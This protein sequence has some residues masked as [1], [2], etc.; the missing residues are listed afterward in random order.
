MRMRAGAAAAFVL[1]VGLATGGL[2]VAAGPEPDCQLNRIGD[3]CDPPTD[4][5]S[6]FTEWAYLS[7][8]GAGAALLL[9]FLFWMTQRRRNR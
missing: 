7:A 4:F 6:L 3:T 2:L 1:V 8:P 9:L 5:G